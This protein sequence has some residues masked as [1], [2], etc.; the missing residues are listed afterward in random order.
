MNIPFTY[1]ANNMPVY[2]NRYEYRQNEFS[3]QYSIIANVMIRQD[4]NSNEDRNDNPIVYIEDGEEVRTEL[5]RELMLQSVI[6][7]VILTL[8]PGAQTLL[9]YIN[10]DPQDK[11]PIPV[12]SSQQMCAEAA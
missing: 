11:A 12:V 3:Y 1:D 7:N 9:E 4:R 10:M 8:D 5:F 6:E 2:G